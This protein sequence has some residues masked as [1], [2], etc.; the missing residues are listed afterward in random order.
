ML[1]SYINK[2]ADAAPL[3][4][5]RIF[6]G[7]LMVWSII[8]FAAN[9]WIEEL[10]LAPGFF[11]SYYGFE[12]IKPLGDATYLLFILCGLSAL[13][14]SLGYKYRLAIITFFLSFTY[15]ELMDKTT[16]LNHYYF[17]SVLSFLMIFLP[18][19]AYFSVDAYRKKAIR[20]KSLPAWTI[21][22]V[23]L[24]LAIVYIYAGLAKL[25]S[26]WL[27]RAMPL[28]IW[29]P[30]KYAL[31]LLGDLF[32]QPWTHYAFSWAGALYDLSI[33]FLLLIPRTRLFA[34]CLVVIFH[35]LTRILFPIGMFP[36]IMIACALI[37]F[38]AS[39]HH[40]ILGFISRLFSI[41]KQTFDDGEYR[42][43]TPFAKKLSVTAVS[44][45]LIVQLL[46]PFRYLLY[47]G[48]L[49]WTEQGYRFSWR[50]MLME[51]AGYAQF[52][53]IDPQ[54]ERRFYVDNTEF[55][56][57]FQEKQMST[58]PDFILEYAHYLKDHYA[59][60][61]IRDPEV[62]VESF[63]ALNGRRSQPYIDPDVNLAAIELSWK[64]KTWILPFDDTIKGL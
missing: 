62:Y 23:K 39:L 42:F 48:E 55:L 5:F 18:A 31:P 43:T 57:R 3:A 60:Q 64:H 33:P 14:V 30:S 17:I 32:Q 21:D 53:I 46:F 40:K 16:Y 52:K 29:L 4:L 56:T 61:G 25:N 27:L 41:N 35:L 45:L 6:F 20:A 47:P 1:T 8:R 63:V 24:L 10:Y 58:Q 22:A 54:T 49:F 15:I 59:D 7:L 19:H 11:F 38:D 9:G 28:Q 44:L 34:F 13:C 12:W 36:Y 50:V 51:K 37:F 2:Q 26:D